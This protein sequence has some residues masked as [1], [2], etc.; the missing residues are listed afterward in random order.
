MVLGKLFSAII[1]LFISNFAIAGQDGYVCTIK[2]SSTV[3]SDG[4]LVPNKNS[5]LRIESKFVVDK[6]TGKVIHGLPKPPGQNT[7][8][9]RGSVSN[10]FKVLWIQKSS[11]AHSI[12]SYLEIQEVMRIYPTPFFFT[13]GL[14]IL[15]GL[16]E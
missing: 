15:S 3:N 14:M 8:I 9:S 13:D 6:N 7:L 12:I 5:I 4:N 16:C 10:N 11:D 2:S 1:F